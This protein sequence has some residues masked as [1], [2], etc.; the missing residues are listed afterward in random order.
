MAKKGVIARGVE[1][2]CLTQDITA[3]FA[4]MNDE[5]MKEVAWPVLEGNGVLDQMVRRKASYLRHA[6]VQKL[7]RYAVRE[8]SQLLRFEGWS[9]EKVREMTKAYALSAYAVHI[10]RRR[11]LLS[12]EFLCSVGRPN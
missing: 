6:S 3:A 4:V 9:D 11:G 1:G 12:V 7:W 10:L 8:K 5:K 2:I